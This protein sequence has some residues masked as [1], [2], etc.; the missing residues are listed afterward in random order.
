MDWK[1]ID[2]PF[3]TNGVAIPYILRKRQGQDMAPYAKRRKGSFTNRRKVNSRPY[4]P[5]KGGYKK[6]GFKVKRKNSYAGRQRRA[7]GSGAL[8]SKVRN[9]V[10][11]SLTAD[12]SFI[13]NYADRVLTSASTINNVAQQYMWCSN[14]ITQDNVAQYTK[15]NL[16][17]DDPLELEKIFTN[18]SNK[19]TCR[20]TRK[21]VEKELTLTN[22]ETTPVEIWE[23]RCQAR[24]DLATLPDT[25]LNTGF[26]G[27]EAGITG[28]VT[29]IMIGATPFM[30]PEFTAQFKIVKVRKRIIQPAR[31]W[32]IK[33]K[34]QKNRL[35]NRA[36]VS[37]AS[38][39][40]NVVPWKIMRGQR[41]S[42]FVAHGSYAANTAATANHK[43]GMGNVGLG[44]IFKTRYHYSWTEDRDIATGY[45][46]G[47]FGFTQGGT[48]S[49]AGHGAIP[50]V[51]NHPDSVI[52]PLTYV[53][54]AVTNAPTAGERVLGSDTQDRYAIR[55][56]QEVQ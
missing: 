16:L 53:A 49:T 21:S 45:S 23:Y 56:D 42:A 41:L 46:N 14:Q 22:T 55:D 15:S 17:L 52:Q 24:R 20:F 11:D 1:H 3:S 44:L 13:E 43:Y 12:N 9:I 27:A 28:K 2:N 38:D 34:Q 5:K 18:I 35:F 30:N 4:A 47:I 7:M 37:P 39:G 36:S 25:Y 51:C 40:V 54:G 32:C 33:Y 50:T 48:S 19:P 31:A 10:M 6:R 8:Q 26:V 29:Q